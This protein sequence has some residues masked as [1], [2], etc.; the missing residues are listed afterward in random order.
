MIRKALPSDAQAIAQ[1]HI[2][3]W[4]AAYRDVMPAQFL[5]GLESTLARR[6]AYWVRSIASGQSIVWLPR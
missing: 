1:V 2:S 3:S 4:Q 6:E 5:K